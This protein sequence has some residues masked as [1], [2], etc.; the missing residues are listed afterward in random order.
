MRFPY[1]FYI[2]P[3]LDERMVRSFGLACE[4]M[5]LN[6]QHITEKVIMCSLPLSYFGFFVPS[7]SNDSCSNHSIQLRLMILTTLLLNDSCCDF[8]CRVN[9]YYSDTSSSSEFFPSTHVNLFIAILSSA[10][11]HHSGD[12]N[13]HF[14][15]VQTKTSRDTNCSVCLVTDA[16]HF[17][18]HG[19]YLMGEIGEGIIEEKLC[20]FPFRT[21]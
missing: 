4:I 20:Q 13:I 16:T 14:S 3:Q 10:P 18:A 8:W 5:K 2:R 6:S 19:S 9:Y 12:N 15:F 7:I 17:L 1:F 21:Q 11:T